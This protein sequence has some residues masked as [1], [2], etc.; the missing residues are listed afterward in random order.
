MAALSSFSLIL[1][2]LLLLSTLVAIALAYRN[3]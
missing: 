3:A 2:V 1:V